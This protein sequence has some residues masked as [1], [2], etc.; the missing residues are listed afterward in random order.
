MKRFALVTCVIVVTITACG[1]ESRSTRTEAAASS[2]PTQA[3]NGGPHQFDRLTLS[4]E[5]ERNEVAT[6]GTI[7]SHLTVSNDTKRSVRDPG[8]LL[9]AFSYG[10]I[11]VDDP[12]AELWG[13]VVVDCSGPFFFRP[14]YNDRFAGATFRATDKYGDPLPP[15]DYLAAIAF[16]RRSERLTQPVTITP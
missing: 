3:S 9:Y 8:C 5:L 1:G 7:D 15:G 2:V 10:L 4:L 6:G 13:Q 12:D 11:P 14:G 16:E